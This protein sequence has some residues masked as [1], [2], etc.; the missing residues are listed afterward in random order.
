MDRAACRRHWGVSTV[1]PCFKQ[2]QQGAQ[3]GRHRAFSQGHVKVSEDGEPEAILVPP[4]SYPPGDMLITI[5]AV[6]TLLVPAAVSHYC[7]SLC[8][9]FPPC[10]C[11]AVLKC[12]KT[13]PSP[14]KSLFRKPGVNREVDGIPF[15]VINKQRAGPRTD[16]TLGSPSW[17]HQKLLSLYLKNNTA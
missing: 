17:E 14:S 16:R 5:C 11:Q 3:V 13:S 12:P 1:I 8:S 6:W 9:Q 15:Q 4:L 10:R 2:G 7:L